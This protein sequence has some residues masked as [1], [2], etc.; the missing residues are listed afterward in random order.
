[1][2]NEYTYHTRLEP[3]HFLQESRPQPATAEQ[4]FWFRAKRLAMQLPSSIDIR[5]YTEAK[6]CF[7]NTCELLKKTK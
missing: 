1:M 6:P 3:Y 7:A 5:E 4:N 2:N